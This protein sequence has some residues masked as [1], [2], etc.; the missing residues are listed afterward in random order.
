MYLEIVEHSPCMKVYNGGIGKSFP[1]RLARPGGDYRWY[2]Q[3]SE[4]GNDL[5]QGPIASK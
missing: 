2:R 4:L 1:D 3:S 5:P